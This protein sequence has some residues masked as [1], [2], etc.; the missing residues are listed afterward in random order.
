MTPAFLSFCSGQPVASEYKWFKGNTHTHTKN[1]DGDSLP[2]TV[3][4]WYSDHGY[5]FLF[6]TD[7]EF[8]TPAAPLNQQF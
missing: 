7:H 6:I 8:I 2:E 3:V 1:S 4:K 5:N